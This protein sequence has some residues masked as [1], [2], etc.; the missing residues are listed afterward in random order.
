MIVSVTGSSPRRRSSSRSAPLH[1]FGIAEN[2]DSVVSTSPSPSAET[3]AKASSHAQTPRVR[4][5]CWALARASPPVEKN[6]GMSAPLPI[7]V[8]Y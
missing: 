4:Q 7:L 2:L 1:R 3:T 8:R 6:D 5:G